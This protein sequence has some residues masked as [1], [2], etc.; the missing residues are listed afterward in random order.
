MRKSKL[1]F[2]LAVSGLIACALPENAQSAAA[3]K[4]SNATVQSRQS[5]KTKMKADS[6]DDPVFACRL[7]ALDA[8]ERARHKALWTELQDHVEQVKELKDGYA[9]RYPA[10]TATILSVAEWVTLERRCCPFFN[11]ALEIE[12]EKQ[13]AWLRITGQK[14]V[15]EFLQLEMS[16]K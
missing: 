10:D 5:S 12:G 7:D 13:S 3:Q 2:I 1:V 16:L 11:F 14:G 8:A 4:R 9:I 15:K 6:K